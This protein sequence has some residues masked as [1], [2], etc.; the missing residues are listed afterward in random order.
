MWSCMFGDRYL[1][2]SV[3]VASLLLG[4]NISLFDSLKAMKM[5]TSN[6][7]QRTA[8]WATGVSTRLLNRH[9]CECSKE[10]YQIALPILFHSSHSFWFSC[11]NEI[12]FQPL[13]KRSSCN[14][15]Y[16]DLEWCVM[17]TS[18]K[19][20]L[21]CPTP[22]SSSDYGYQATWTNDGVLTCTSDP[23]FNLSDVC[24]PGQ[25]YYTHTASGWVKHPASAPY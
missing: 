5:I 10:L 18:I 6:W 3:V 20:H 9:Q 1:G 25:D 2:W 16:F 21:T 11:Y 8:L 7:I 19:P 24:P 14:C 23:K 15:T 12:G 17:H 4:A 13:V 22:L